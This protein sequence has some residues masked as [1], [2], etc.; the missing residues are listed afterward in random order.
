VT[1]PAATRWLRAFGGLAKD[2][3]KVAW[4]PIRFL[5]V[6]TAFLCAAG[7]VLMLIS[8]GQPLP[9]SQLLGTIG[10]LVS[11]LLVVGWFVIRRIRGP[12]PRTPAAA[13]G[14]AVVDSMNCPQCSLVLPDGTTECPKCGW[15]KSSPPTKNDWLDTWELIKGLFYLAVFLGG[16]GYAIYGLYGSVMEHFET[17]DG[18]YKKA[19]K[20]YDDAEKY[21]LRTTKCDELAEHAG[22]LESREKAE[23][24]CK[25]QGLKFKGTIGKEVECEP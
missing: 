14:G 17:S 23:R 12:S 19:A 11:S 24:F 2:L 10:V 1:S 7:A 16:G 4:V 25:G 6:L 18:V 20:C 15:T 13:R 3:A 8:P 22:A 21:H 5:I 9:R